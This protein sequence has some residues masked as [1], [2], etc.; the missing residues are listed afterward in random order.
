MGYNKNKHDPLSSTMT[1]GD[2]LEELRARLILAI[3][4]IVICTVISLWFSRYLIIFLQKP[5]TNLMGDK[6]L[7]ALSL[8]EGFVSYVKIALIAGLVVSSPWVFYQIWMFV[9]AGLY[10]HEKRYVHIAVPFSAALFIGGA[11]FFLF[12]VA[13]ISIGWLVKVNDWLGLNTN[14]TFK[15]YINFVTSLMLVF[16]AAFQ[17]P[18]AIFFL[19]RSGLV[20]LS[21][22]KGARKYVILAIVIIAAI[23]TPPDV[24]SQ[25]TLAIPMYMLYE[26]GI[27]LCRL[28]GGRN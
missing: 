1:L 9:A 7:Q 27:I 11:L 26:L 14:I 12:L 19:N 8:T 10:E 21:A 16:G 24:V 28:A 2:H 6:A 4:G 25:I 20:S 13:P 23:A 5:Y 15:N 22:L 18:T 3:L 17:T